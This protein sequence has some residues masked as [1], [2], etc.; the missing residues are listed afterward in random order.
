MID[1]SRTKNYDDVA[2]TQQQQQHEEDIN[3]NDCSS[4]ISCYTKN[5][6]GHL[7]LHWLQ[8][9]D[10]KKESILPSFR[11]LQQKTHRTL[12]G[13][14]TIQLGREVIPRDKSPIG[15]VDTPIQHLVDLINCH[16]RFCTLSSCSGRMSLFDPNGSSGSSNG[17]DDDGKFTEGSGKGRGTWILVSHEKLCPEELV[18]AMTTTI[19]K[20]TTSVGTKSDDECDSDVCGDDDDD[21]GDDDDD[22][23]QQKQ[24]WTFRFETLLLHIAAA[25]LN[26]GRKLLT[27]ALNLGFRESGLVVTDKRVTV[28]IRSNSLSTATPLFPPTT[29]NNTNA[30]ANANATAT[31]ATSTTLDKTTLPCVPV[32]F[33]RFLVED[34]NTRLGSNWNLLDRLYRSIESTLFEIQSL[35][36]PIT[37]IPRHSNTNSNIPTLNL[38]NVAAT[39]VVVTTTTPTDV[40]AT[41][42]TAA[43]AATATT[44][45]SQMTTS[46]TKQ[47]L[48]IAGGYGCGPTTSKITTTTSTAAK[49]SSK[50]Y[51]LERELVS[52]DAH[53]DNDGGLWQEQWQAY[54]RPSNNDNNN[55]KDSYLY[56][57]TVPPPSHSK[58]EISLNCSNSNRKR[59][60]RLGV[61][62]FRDEEKFPDLQGMTSCR[63]E[64]SGLV[65]FWGGR[66]GPTKPALAETLYVFENSNTC[67]RFGTVIDVRGDLPLSRWGHGLVALS[68]GYRAILMGGCNIEDGALDDVFVLHL[69]T[70]DQQQKPGGRD[71]NDESNDDANGYFYW[72]RLS[73]RL[74]TPRFHFGS[75][76]LKRDT[77][78]VVGGLQSTQQLLQPFEHDNDETTTT[79]WACRFGDSKKKKKNKICLPSTKATVV[80]I[81]PHGGPALYSDTKSLFGT[82][83]CTMMSN[84]LLFVTGGIQHGKSL[85]ST[86]L[87]AYWISNNQSSSSKVSTLRLQRIALGYDHNNMNHNQ[88]V[89]R[90]S[91]TVPIDF[92]SLVHHC[93]ITISDNEFLLLGGG[94]A[95]FAFGECYAR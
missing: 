31:T 2:S 54:D 7:P 10:E 68:T 51:R 86:P 50:L 42:A 92:R 44:S 71:S 82:A 19:K 70:E 39:T 35:P 15:S 22:N 28:A 52:R 77:I 37:I 91:T 80:T 14:D 23:E 34:A 56:L 85:K 49:R 18:K 1:D 17:N 87:Q 67:V 25:S 47:Q 62:W 33:L 75:A 40:V 63:L 88:Q 48:W 3:N 89:D 55:N 46:T 72:E 69:C 95:S 8:P 21:D 16:S 59:R 29:N 83:C 60:T 11:D 93:C 6:D 79:T 5:Y 13:S 66:K 12:Y 65:L 36:P 74:P 26:D 24:P 61:R 90:N 9:I 43:A 32:S 73:I 41:I 27:I 53:G 94:V 78:V 45:N 76:L 38:W 57:P 30:N 84:N 4:Q 58:Q 81:D 64:E 20:K